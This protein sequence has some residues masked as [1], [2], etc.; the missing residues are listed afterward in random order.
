MIPSDHCVL[1]TINVNDEQYIHTLIKISI[2]RETQ[3]FDGAPAFSFSAIIRINLDNSDAHTG[4]H[5]PVGEGILCKHDMNFRKPLTPTQI[6][7]T[8]T[9]KAKKIGNHLYR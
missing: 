2:V 8:D 7:R 4:G 6:Q 5:R 9:A 3:Q 1:Y